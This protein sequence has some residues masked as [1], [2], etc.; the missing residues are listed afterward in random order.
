MLAGRGISIMR[1]LGI[2]VLC[3][4]LAGCGAFTQ[5]VARRLGAQ[6]IGKSTD[7]MVKDFGP[8]TS[9]FKLQSG[10]TSYDWQLD[11]VTSIRGADSSR[12]IAHT[13]FCK[14]TVISDTR[15]IVTDLRTQDADSM[16]GSICAQRLG[17]MAQ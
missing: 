1:N 13:N 10:E 7:V 17:I 3:A 9:S 14:V 6:Y 15:G 16:Y 2:A 5:E 8:P 11:A 12:A 4:A